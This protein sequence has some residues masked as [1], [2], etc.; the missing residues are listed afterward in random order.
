MTNLEIASSILSGLGGSDNIKFVTHCATRLRVT[1]NN[2]NKINEENITNISGVMGLV[3]RDDELQVI[4]G[5]SVS[6]VYNEFIKLG[7]FNN[8]GAIESKETEKADKKK[9][10]IFATATDFIAAA[11]LPALP[12][13]VAGGLMSAILVL[14]TS[15]FGLSK[16]SGT[17]IILNSVYVAAYS[18]LPIYVGY[19]TAS[20]LGISPMLGALLG[21]VLVSGDISGVAGLDFLGIPVAAVGYG[22]SVLPVIFGVLFMQFIYRPLEKHTPQEVKFF[23]VPLITMLIAVPITLLVLGPL[24]SWIGEL[25]GHGLTWLNNTIGWLSVGLVGGTFA[26]MLFTGTGYGLYPIVIAGFGTN[27]MESF[28]QPAGLAANLAV[29]GAAIAVMTLLKDEESK[30]TSFST[31]LTAL[32]GITEPAIFGVLARYR[33]PFIGAAIGGAVG[34]IFAGLLHVTQYAFV[35]P[36][37]ASIISFVAPDG[38]TSNLIMAIITMVIAFTVSFIVTRF[39]GIEKKE[40]K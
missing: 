8:G 25:I 5:T 31:G 6:S 19:N 10:S 2:I 11:V 40:V 38:T 14:C 7:D 30:G 13:L 35:S 34:G 21:G 33:K 24:G 32:F 23:I 3:K 1:V 29:A 36:G 15:F 12:I 18:F 39:I 17:Y 28:V 27:N 26:L 16:D 37:V 22:S 4:I 20:K 9:T